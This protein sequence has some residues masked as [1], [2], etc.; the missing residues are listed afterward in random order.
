MSVFPGGL[1]TSSGLVDGVRGTD[2]LGEEKREGVEELEGVSGAR[3][4]E[5]LDEEL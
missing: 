2:M 4:E 5:P 3:I 1:E